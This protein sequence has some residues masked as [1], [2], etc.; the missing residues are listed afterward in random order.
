MVRLYRL[1]RVSFRDGVNEEEALAVEHIVLPHRTVWVP[2]PNIPPLS[3]K[4]DSCHKI[5]QIGEPKGVG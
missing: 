4:Q 1:K 3:K 2:N 5:R